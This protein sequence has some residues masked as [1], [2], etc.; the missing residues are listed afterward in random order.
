MV[1]KLNNNVNTWECSDNEPGLEDARAR[2]IYNDTHHMYI[3]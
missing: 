1:S 3:K 2:A